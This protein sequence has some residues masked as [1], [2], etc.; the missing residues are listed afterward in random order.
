M[1]AVRTLTGLSFSPEQPWFPGLAHAAT[2][3]STAF[4]FGVQACLTGLLLATLA[5]FVVYLPLT[6]LALNGGRAIRDDAEAPELT[7]KAQLALLVLWTLT[8]WIVASL[9]R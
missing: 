1:R 3:L 7:L 8:V 2:G 9:A 4:V 5:S 6:A